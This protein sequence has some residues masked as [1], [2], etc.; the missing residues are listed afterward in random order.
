MRCCPCCAMR[1]ISSREAITDTT[2]RR[3]ASLHAAAVAGLIAIATACSLPAPTATDVPIGGVRQRITRENL[4]A[5]RIGMA[6]GLLEAGWLPVRF[7][8]ANA[9]FVESGGRVGSVDLVYEHPDGHF[10]HI[11]QTH[12]SPEDLGGQDP[13]AL[14]EPIP[15]SDWNANALSAAQTGRAGVVEF[16]TRLDDGRTVSIDS[17]LDR[18]TM[19]RVLDSLILRS[20]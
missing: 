9:D 10:V 1:S 5:A 11:F 8:L 7:T 3:T 6:G 18:A 12:A 4:H 16:S 2:M 19:L 14:G 17:D 20:D 15:S 13:V